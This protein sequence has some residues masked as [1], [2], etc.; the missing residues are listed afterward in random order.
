MWLPSYGRTKVAEIPR[1]VLSEHFQERMEGRRLVAAVFLTYQFDP[2]FFEQEILPVL[3]DIPLSHAAPIRVVQLQDAILTSGTQIAVYYDAGGLVQG[4]GSAKLDVRRIPVRIGR[5]SFVFHPKNILLLTEDMEPDA[6][7]ERPPTLLCA[8]LS[9]NL[10]RSGW[11]ENVEVCHVEEIIAGQKSR[12]KEPLLWFLNSIRGWAKTELE[13]TALRQIQGF[14]RGT[15]QRSVHSAAGRLYPHFYTGKE[16]LVD[17]LDDAAGSSLR[18]AYLEIISPY[19]DDATECKPLQQL[20]KRFRPRE[21][22]V[23]LPRGNAG[24]AMCGQAFFESIQAM[25]GVCWGH[26]SGDWLRFGRSE[27]SG[28]RFVHAK[29]YRFFTPKPKREICFVGS[30]NLTT[31]A[32]RARGNIESG[33]LVEC[34]PARRPEFWLIPDEQPVVE[35]R[36]SSD[37]EDTATAAGT[38]LS[39]RFHWDRHVAEAFWDGSNESPELRL[40]IRGVAL[41]TIGPLLPRE[42]MPLGAE[43]ADRLEPLLMETSFIDVQ[44]EGTQ[45]GV[46]LVQE[47]GMSHKPSL[48]FQLSAGDILRYWSLLTPEQRSAFIEPRVPAAGLG[49][50]GT[51]TFVLPPVVPE[52]DSLFDRFAGF[53]HA[54]GSLETSLRN[55]LNAESPRE[56]EAV[57]RLFGKKY[58]SL[59]SLLDCVLD[60][61]GVGDDVNQYVIVLCAQQLCREISRSFP[62]FWRAH[63]SD[64]RELERRLT[65]GTATIR[66]RLI[67]RNPAEMSEFLDWFDPW[68]L[69]RAKALEPEA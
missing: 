57:Y 69:K 36:P 47:E 46:L 40:L 11:W 4:D 65:A 13:H 29:V 45:P 27:D 48:L 59:G 20:I 19:F 42:W 60:G 17:F 24:E 64:V 9:A 16:S 39:L 26:L 67:T 54:F 43:F 56:T 23:F 3:L 1:S 66:Q 55:A 32:H 50:Q 25:Q 41:G 58:D 15:E 44:G 49:D 33:F 61:T 2:A 68:F 37:G 30:A 7:G 31:A 8:A 53:F 12:L 21:V 35:Y 10:T 34:E 28:A 22:R 38:R 63:R 5:G 18:G 51:D 62:E 6:S 52:H 14:L